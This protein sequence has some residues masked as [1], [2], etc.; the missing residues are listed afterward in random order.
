MIIMCWLSEISVTFCNEL[1]VYRA[2]K[3]EYGYA[4]DTQLVLSK[5]LEACFHRNKFIRMEMLRNLFPAA[6]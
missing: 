5:S 3:K 4:E 6:N 2:L 1:Q